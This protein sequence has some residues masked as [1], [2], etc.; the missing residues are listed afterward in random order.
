MANGSPS[1]IIHP[2]C[3]ITRA[4]WMIII[5]NTGKT[6][7]TTKNFLL[8]QFQRIT[9]TRGL[10]L[11]LHGC[12][13][14]PMDHR[15]TETE[16]GIGILRWWVGHQLI[17][18]WRMVT[19]LDWWVLIYMRRTVE[20]ALIAQRTRRFPSTD[21]CDWIMGGLILPALGPQAEW[22]LSRKWHFSTET[23]SNPELNC[24]GFSMVS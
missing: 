5:L 4:Q 15:L 10:G 7:T 11:M 19:T 14:K 2:V 12:W 23:W 6:T 16:F 20:F 21:K 18:I 24:G 9:W 1:G 22:Q 8:R 3:L 13:P 17:I